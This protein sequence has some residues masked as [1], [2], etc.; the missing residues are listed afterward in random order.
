MIARLFTGE[1]G[2]AMTLG[3][4]GLSLLLLVQFIIL[5]LARGISDSQKRLH[6]AHKALARAERLAREYVRLGGAAQPDGGEIDV[7][8]Q[9]TLFARMEVAGRGLK[10][11]SMVESM[12]P[13]TKTLPDGSERQQVR[14]RLSGL[15]MGELLNYLRECETVVGGRV[16][17]LGLRR[18]R[19]RLLDVD[20]VVVQPE[21]S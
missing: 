8:A 9:G 10:L 5:P 11:D 3:V 20:M 14:V 7:V 21:D 4:A 19:D 12:R 15:G 2:R 6:G 17:S 13:E 18:N 16:D 1:H